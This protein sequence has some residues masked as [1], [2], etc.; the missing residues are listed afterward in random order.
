MRIRKIW[1]DNWRHF[2]NIELALGD[3]VGLVCIVGANGTGKSHLLELISACANR[4]G[5]SAGVDIPRGDPFADTHKLSV[6]FHIPKGISDTIDPGLE[7]DPSYLTWDRTLTIESEKGPDR[8]VTRILAGGTGDEGPLIKFANSVVRCLGDARDVHFLSLDA[9]RAYPNRDVGTHQVAEAYQIDWLTTE[10]TRGRSYRSSA[11]LYDEWKR[12]FLA[13]ENRTATEHVKA[14]RK[15][16]LANEKEPAFS[17]HFEPYKDALLKVLPHIVFTGVD[18]NRRTLVF[19]TTGLELSFNQLS[20]GEREIAFLVGQ[21]DRFRLRHGLLL[22]DEPELH[23]NADLI[24]TWVGYLTGTVESGQIW[25]ATHS[26]EASKQ[27]DS[28]LLSSLNA[29]R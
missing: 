7:N 23:L 4:I 13:R 14:I 22:I 24:R 5:L 1:I 11:T 16:R 12:Y 15:A 9:D 25:L 10:Y 27:P 29:M 21:I 28:M 19:D 18:T 26:L 17:D 20:G 8:S 2:Q 6:A 3:D